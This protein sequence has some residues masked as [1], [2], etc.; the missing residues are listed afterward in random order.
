MYT[1]LV[2]IWEGEG[3]EHIIESDFADVGDINSSLI[4]NNGFPEV[5]AM[6]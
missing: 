3:W 4:Q 6:V 2:G 1:S 5:F